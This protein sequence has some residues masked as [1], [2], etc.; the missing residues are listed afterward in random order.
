MRH[1]ID[2]AVWGARFVSR[3]MSANG[4][5]YHL[6]AHQAASHSRADERPSNMKK[7]EEHKNLTN[8][9]TPISLCHILRL[10]RADSVPRTS[11]PRCPYDESKVSFAGPRR[12]LYHIRGR[13][14]RGAYDREGLRQ[15]RHV[16]TVGGVCL[17]AW[18]D[19]D[20]LGRVLP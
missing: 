10:E 6:T 4:S 12:V 3:R 9:T 8:P 7:E 14:T 15:S 18:A 17:S 20:A 2:P 11:A 1:Q 5:L 19:S 16:R 13:T